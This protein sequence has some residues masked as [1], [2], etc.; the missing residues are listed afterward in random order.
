MVRPN[1]P[2]PTGH[3]TDQLP[4]RP[5][6]IGMKKDYLLRVPCLLFLR[7]LWGEESFLKNSS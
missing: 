6:G 2:A 3:L 5:L 1:R 4:Y 7:G